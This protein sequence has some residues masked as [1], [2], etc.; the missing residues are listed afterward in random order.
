MNARRSLILFTLLLMTAAS[1]Q[2]Q[3]GE[4]KRHLRFYTSAR[5]F[6]F[7]LQLA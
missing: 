1:A 6:V 5:S 7:K 4:Q 3:T 2:A